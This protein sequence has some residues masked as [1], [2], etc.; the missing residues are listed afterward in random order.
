[1]NNGVS[2]RLGMGGKSFCN[3]LFWN[4]HGQVTK[5]IG[6]KFTDVE[7][8]NVCKNFDILGVAELHTNST[9]GIKGFKLIKN[10]IRTKLHKGPKI[11]GGIAVFAKKEI[12]H[13]V[14]LVPNDNEDSIWV[15]LPK[16]ST[17]EVNDIYIGTCY[18]SPPGRNSKPQGME[19]DK[20]DCL[21]SF[22]EEVRKSSGF[23]NSGN[24]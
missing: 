8:L 24:A 6:N 19:N 22:F 18:I 15:R 21:Y 13:M 7:F 17:G 2:N 3:I 5:T 23:Q 16:E 4:V 9:P 11:S 20:H 14:R 12:S 10:K 1:M